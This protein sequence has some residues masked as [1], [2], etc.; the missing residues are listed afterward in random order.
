MFMN[1]NLNMKETMENR[2]HDIIKYKETL[3]EVKVCARRIMLKNMIFQNVSDL[4]PKG[5]NTESLGWGYGY[6]LK[7]NTD[8]NISLA[9][10]DKIMTK[11]AKKINTEPHV[12]IS[13]DHMEASFGL[14]TNMN[15]E[16]YNSVYL[17]FVVG[18]TEKCDF[19]TITEQVTKSAPTGYCKL[20]AEKRF[21]QTTN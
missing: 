16:F 13:E 6:K 10:F 20:L 15:S 7:P 11:F 2:K 21:L 19:E 17:E 1:V 3:R 18:N 4:I 8:M 12:Y 5:W 14:C 9:D